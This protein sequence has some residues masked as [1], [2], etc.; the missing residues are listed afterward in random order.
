M[1]PSRLY[2]WIRQRIPAWVCHYSPFMCCRSWVVIS[3]WPHC[4]LWLYRPRGILTVASRCYSNALTT[5]PMNSFNRKMC[6]V[7]SSQ[8]FF[9]S[10]FF[11]QSVPLLSVLGGSKAPKTFFKALFLVPGVISRLRLPAPCLYKTL[12]LKVLVLYCYNITK[13]QNSIREQK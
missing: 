1:H 7:G 12:L 13:C 8:I 9:F 2:V 4:A 5:K 3:L 10:L 6:D 11:F